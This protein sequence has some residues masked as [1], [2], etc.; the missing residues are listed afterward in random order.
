VAEL[1]P[2]TILTWHDHTV[3]IRPFAARSAGGATPAEA[4]RDSIARQLRS[5]RPTA[6][7]L[8]GG[9]DSALLAAVAADTGAPVSALT[10]STHDNSEDVRLAAAPARPGI[11][12]RADCA[13]APRP[14]S[15]LGSAN[16]HP[17]SRRSSTQV[18]R[19]R[20]G[21]P[22]GA[23]STTT[24]SAGSPAGSRNRRRDG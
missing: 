11:G 17:D 22:G 23:S 19:L 7:F 9:F 3:R 16:P 6:L 14:R 24:R 8:S 13:R 5:D 15:H 18:R 12:S 4:A 20:H 21:R 2:G 1:E 10:L